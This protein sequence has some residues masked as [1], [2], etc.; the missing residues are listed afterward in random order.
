M[1]EGQLEEVD[2]EAMRREKKAEQGKAQTL[3]ELIAV[4]MARGYKNPKA[5]AIHVFNARQG[6]HSGNRSEQ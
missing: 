6:K 3:Q 5:W 2:V 1:V 4:G